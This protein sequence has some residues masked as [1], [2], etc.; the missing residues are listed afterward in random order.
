MGNVAAVETAPSGQSEV[1]SFKR[2]LQDI[3]RYYG[4]PASE[5][6]LFSGVP[7]PDDGIEP[8]LVER[9]CER[10]GLDIAVHTVRDVAAGKIEFP[11]LVEF[12]DGRF[13]FLDG[14]TWP[15]IDAGM[16]ARQTARTALQALARQGI[17]HAYSFSVIYLNS[18]ERA[19]LGGSQ[20]IERGHW[21]FG[22]RQPVL[23]GLR[24]H[25]ACCPVHQPARAGVAD[26]HHE[27][28]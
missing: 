5:T 26:L 21:L 9:I 20:D 14:E 23:A 1:E 6:V 2:C 8:V 19:E 18:A 13:A 16:D 10:I 7:L 11:A 17:R 27:C 4:R 28:L 15:G 3:A 25:C 12:A 24:Q 22:A